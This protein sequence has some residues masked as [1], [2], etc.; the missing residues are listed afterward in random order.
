VLR[1]HAEAFG[2]SG[3]ETLQQHVGLG[4]QPQH[5]VP[6]AVR[7]EIG[8]HR[9]AVPQQV[10]RLIPGQAESRYRPVHSHHV[11]AQ[12]GEDHRRVRRRS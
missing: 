4:R 9:P 5:Q 11:G 7:L 3:P 1:A 6:A 12:V 2:H 8:G 10:V